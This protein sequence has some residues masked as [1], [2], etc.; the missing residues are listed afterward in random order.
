MKE[1]KTFTLL[2]SQN[3]DYNHQWTAGRLGHFSIQ[4]EIQLPVIYSSQQNDCRWMYQ[5]PWPYTTR[6]HCSIQLLMKNGKWNLQF[7]LKMS[8]GCNGN[9]IHKNSIGKKIC[10][11]HLFCINSMSKTKKSYIWEKVI[12][13]LLL[14]RRIVSVLPTPGSDRLN[15]PLILVEFSQVL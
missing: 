4:G 5:S 7:F 3:K 11:N 12:T 13:L 6:T 2:T 14:L 8:I 1:N 9:S 15:C 10:R